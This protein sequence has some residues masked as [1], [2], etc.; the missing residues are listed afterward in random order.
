MQVWNNEYQRWEWHEEQR[1]NK[2]CIPML[3]TLT[4][5][6]ITLAGG[7]ILYGAWTDGRLSV[8]TQQGITAPQQPDA[9]TIRPTAVIS[10]GIALPTSTPPS[11]S[12]YCANP[13]NP[14]C[15][16][17]VNAPATVSA[18]QQQKRD[19]IETRQAAAMETVEAMADQFGGWGSDE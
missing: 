10:P 5:I 13:N 12:D 3:M 7:I 16:P 11:E 9:S 6:L 8:N 14:G 2:G 18:I 15:A 1:R 17:A 4:I 19:E